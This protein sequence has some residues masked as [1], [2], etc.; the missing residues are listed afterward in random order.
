MILKKKT[1]RWNRTGIEKN[2]GRCYSEIKKY[3]NKEK[4][5]K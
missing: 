2:S 4:T 3:K 1:W 5:L